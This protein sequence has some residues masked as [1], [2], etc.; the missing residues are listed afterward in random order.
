MWQVAG[1]PVDDSDFGEASAVTVSEQ[2]NTRAN[3]ALQIKLRVASL[4]RTL[5]A[6]AM[7]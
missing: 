1:Q 5:A 4:H 3:P 2:K 6:S 7:P